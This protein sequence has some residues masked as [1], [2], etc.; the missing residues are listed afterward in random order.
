MDSI[1]AN[2]RRTHTVDSMAKRAKMSP[3]TFARPFKEAT[4]TTP[5]RC[6]MRERVN[7]AQSLLEAGKWSIDQVA[8]RS[9]FG[10]A[11]LLR[12]HFR[13]VVGTSPTE[14]RRSFRS[15]PA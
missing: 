7:L 12:L 13:R 2:L 10:D 4:G 5:Y 3:R 6:L 9:A 11:L 8:E 1:R 14:Y 15:E